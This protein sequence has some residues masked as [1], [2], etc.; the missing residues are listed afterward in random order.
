MS[1]K[2]TIIVAALINA[3]LLIILFVS[4][5]KN[6][7]STEHAAQSSEKNAGKE[8]ELSRANEPKVAIGDEVDQVL[9]QYARQNPLKE[10]QVKT[11]SVVEPVS[12]A[13]VENV[14][15]PLAISPQSFVDDLTA[16]TKASEP[17]SQKELQVADKPQTNGGFDEVTVKR[18]DVLEKIARSH[19]I[20]VQELMRINKLSSSN[21]KIGQVLKVPAQ[22]L[23]VKP[24]APKT[25]AVASKVE[26]STRMYTVK[27]GDNPWTIAVKNHMKV[28]DLLRLNNMDEAKAR[29]LKPGDQ[30]RIR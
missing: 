18:G 19:H 15:E 2:D 27:A 17:E 21:L 10:A 20:S 14:I 29:K 25:E 6:P 1:R 5:L 3:G 23:A 30:I 26:P 16:L 28:E 7:S 24:S 12:T 8:L 13:A 9:S 4:A 22:V 11:A